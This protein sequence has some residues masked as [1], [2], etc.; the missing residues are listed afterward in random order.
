MCL[1]LD[2]Y[3]PWADERARTRDMCGKVRHLQYVREDIHERISHRGGAN[4]LRTLHA[5]RALHLRR[6]GRL[7]LGTIPLRIQISDEEQDCFELVTNRG[8]I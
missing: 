4:A 8:V 3:A 5:H 6:P 1:C 7:K 2:V